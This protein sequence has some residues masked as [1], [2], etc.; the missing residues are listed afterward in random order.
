MFRRV[1]GV[2]LAFLLGFVAFAPQASAVA[3]TVVQPDQDYA[4]KTYSQWSTSWWQ[5]AAGISKPSPAG[6]S[7]GVNCAIGQSGPVWFLVGTFGAFG[8]S[9]SPRCSV[10][11]GKA[12]LV[13]IVNGESSTVERDGT[14]DA[15]LRACA[16]D[17]INHVSQ[18]RLT[19][20]GIP[21]INNDATAA[22]FRFQSPAFTITFAPNNGFGVRP[23]G[24]GMSVADGYWG[25]VKPLPVGL[26]EIDFSG[27]YTDNG[28]SYSL[29]V[30]YAITVV[31]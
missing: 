31:G 1:I 8:T 22:K 10:P 5:W 12:I 21:L 18:A 29:D 14:T 25:L 16:V 3:P 20:D 9:T 28:T 15:E 30:H 2:V 27:I 23:P 11:V 19:V 6:D 13:P 26:H 17:Q 24:T 4:G 7:T